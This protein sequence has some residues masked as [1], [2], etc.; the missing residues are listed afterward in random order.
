MNWQPIENAPKDK[1]VLLWHDED[2]DVGIYNDG[3]GYW[4]I[5][6]GEGIT[7][8]H[9]ML[10]TPPGEQQPDADLMR[11]QLLNCHE[12]MREQAA[13]IS[14]LKATLVSKCREQQPESVNQRLLDAIQ[15]LR[16]CSECSEGSLENCEVGQEVLA[17][18]EAAKQATKGT[19][20]NH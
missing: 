2:F 17:A 5:L 6:T 14:E 16:M 10:I 4:E 12:R 9:F 1:Y 19:N 11:E 8:T 3:R 15:H 7:P 18:I 20:E 13:T